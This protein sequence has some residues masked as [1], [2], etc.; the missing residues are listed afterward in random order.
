[1]LDA[2]STAGSKPTSI[3]DD[4]HRNFHVQ[5]SP[6]GARIAF[7]SDRDG[8]RGVYIARADG[9]EPRKISGMPG[10]RR[11]EKTNTSRATWLASRSGSPI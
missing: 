5:P 1:M 7:D 6:D 11:L 3:L 2:L 4:G 8:E 10:S 9:R